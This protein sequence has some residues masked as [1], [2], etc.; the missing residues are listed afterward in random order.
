[1]AHSRRLRATAYH[2]AGHAVSAYMA[3]RRFTRVSIVPDNWSLG[4]CT[5]AA[6]RLFP[7]NGTGDRK[8]RARIEREIMIFCG[9]SVAEAL[10]M[11]RPH[12]WR[13]ASHDL[14]KA[15]ELAEYAT[16][17][18]DEAKAF[19]TWLLKRSEALL[20]ERPWRRATT[21]LASELLRHGELGERQARAT[22][23]RAIRG[24]RRRRIQR[25]S[26]PVIPARPRRIRTRR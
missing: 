19:T 16:H 22:I 10:H 20:R 26:L 12:S 14:H 3:G 6:L 13:W 17:N 15:T 25:H 9:G 18:P 8:G 21:A 4:R 2:E 1:M 11:K 5:F 23:A 24:R 7:L